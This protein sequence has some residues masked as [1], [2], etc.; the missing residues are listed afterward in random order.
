MNEVKKENKSNEKD[1]EVDNLKKKRMAGSLVLPAGV[2]FKDGK[3]TFMESPK[4][5][6][7]SP[8]AKL[9]MIVKR[10]P[11]FVSDTPICQND[12]IFKD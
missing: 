8:R 5:Q 7:S 12:Y 9:H 1:I 11:E 6:F 2:R 3:S 10:K 4:T